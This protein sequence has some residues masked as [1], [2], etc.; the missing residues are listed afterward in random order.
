LNI[1]FRDKINMLTTEGEYSTESADVIN[2]NFNR[3]NE[4][5][6]GL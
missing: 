4:D 6:A 2:N 5:L 1:D 3:L